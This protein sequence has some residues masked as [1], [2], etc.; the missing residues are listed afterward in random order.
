[1]GT[2][3][4]FGNRGPSSASVNWDLIATFIILG[5]L[6]KNSPKATAMRPEVIVADLNRD[7]GFGFFR[8]MA[9]DGVMSDQLTSRILFK[10]ALEPMLKTSAACD[11]EVFDSHLSPMVTCQGQVGFLG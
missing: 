11:L 8:S 7:L 4:H 6:R 9:V 10:Y 3:V 1:M 2:L 5:K